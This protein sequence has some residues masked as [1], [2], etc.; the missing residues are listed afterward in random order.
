MSAV[1]QNEEKK[2]HATAKPY[3]N[4]FIIYGS[5]K[6]DSLEKSETGST[7]TLTGHVKSMTAKT[8]EVVFSTQKT[9]QVTDKND[10][11]ALANARKELADA[12]AEEIKYGI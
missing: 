3:A 2:I 7:Y 6:I 5:V 12:I 1:I 11:N 8:G 10:W 4:S 9:V